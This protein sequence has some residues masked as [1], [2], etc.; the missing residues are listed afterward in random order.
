MISNIRTIYIVALVLL[1]MNKV[2][3]GK[4]YSVAFKVRTVLMLS[5]VVFGQDSKLFFVFFS[6]PPIIS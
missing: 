6:K 1:G 4:S 3:L 5:I 2:V